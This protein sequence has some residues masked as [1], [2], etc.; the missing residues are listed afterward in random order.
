MIFLC[1]W[2][3]CD[4][5]IVKKQLL[6]HEFKHK[7]GL[8]NTLCFRT[9][10]TTNLDPRHYLSFRSSAESSSDPITSSTLALSLLSLMS[11][12]MVFTMTTIKT[13]KPQNSKRN[14]FLPVFHWYR[15]C[16]R[17]T[18][19]VQGRPEMAASSTLSV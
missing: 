3:L 10:S 1:K 7:P 8:F 15:S 12:L 11:C 2:T 18:Q 5:I 16:T 13:P 14:T 4:L 19:N 17:T 6:V 9:F